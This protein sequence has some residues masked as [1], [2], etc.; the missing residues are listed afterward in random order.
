MTRADNEAVVPRER[1]RC[2]LC[3][4]GARPLP[5]GV[6]RRAWLSR[7]SKGIFFLVSDTDHI[8]PFVSRQTDVYTRF[9]LQHFLSLLER[10]FKS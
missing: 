9:T 1:H 3:S 6:M 4:G 8:E 5:V 7:A 10:K 2:S